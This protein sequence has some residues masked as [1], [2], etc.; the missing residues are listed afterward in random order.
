MQTTRRERR[1]TCPVV[2]SSPPVCVCMD[3]L[4][5]SDANGVFR[6]WR[7]RVMSTPLPFTM[8]SDPSV[9][10]ATL[11][12]LVE[13]QVVYERLSAASSSSSMCQR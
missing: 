5:R 2:W 1:V 3:I 10:R 11:R 7:R 9:D 12:A 4:S 13:I 6:R 8:P